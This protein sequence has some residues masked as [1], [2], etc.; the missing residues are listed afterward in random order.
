[1]WLSS[2]WIPPSFSLSGLAQGFHHVAA[3]PQLS[4]DTDGPILHDH[5]RRRAKCVKNHAPHFSAVGA[6]FLLNTKSK[7]TAHRQRVLT[8]L[9]WPRAGHAVIPWR[10][11]D[12]DAHH[13]APRPGLA[14][15]TKGELGGGVPLTLSAL[16]HCKHCN[17]L[18]FHRFLDPIRSTFDCCSSC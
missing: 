6:G 4:G 16:T 1:M 2:R 18:P 17:N 14:P 13:R 5:L 7:K 10:A 12:G 15:R 9:R 3:R 11:R 8:P